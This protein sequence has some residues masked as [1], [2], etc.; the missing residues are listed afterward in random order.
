MKRHGML[1]ASLLRMCPVPTREPV[2]CDRT[3]D[4]E[5]WHGC[6][7]ERDM[8]AQDYHVTMD[9]MTLIARFVDGDFER[10]SDG[11]GRP[12]AKTAR[13]AFYASKLAALCQSG[14]AAFQGVEH[15][16]REAERKPFTTR[17]AMWRTVF[18]AMWYLLSMWH[19]LGEGPRTYHHGSRA[20]SVSYHG[21]N[22]VRDWSAIARRSVSLLRDPPPWAW[23]RGHFVE[24]GSYH[25]SYNVLPVRRFTDERSAVSVIAY[26]F[27]GRFTLTCNEES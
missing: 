15:V 12:I 27:D 10:V 24:P 14:P 25:G 21:A 9:G 17:K 23:W 2:G 16:V 18:E 26:L 1:R 11:N 7:R 3:I 6:E 19:H 20:M 8:A 4:R 13:S 5:L 22:R